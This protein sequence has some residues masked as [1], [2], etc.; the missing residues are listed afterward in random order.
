MA[1]FANDMRYAAC[2]TSPGKQ[3]RREFLAGAAA[4]GLAAASASGKA[5]AAQ[6]NAM[7]QRPIPSSGEMVPAVGMGTWITFN[8]GS[9]TA[10]RADRA[11]VLRTFFGMGGKMVDSSPMYGTSEEVIGDCLKRIGGT[12]PLLSATKVWTMFERFGITQ[13]ER[14]MELW[15]VP[16]F[17]LMQIHNLLDWDTHIKTLKEWKAAGRIRY[18]GITTS[19]GRRH[20]NFAKVMQSEPLDFVQ[21]SY[22]I[23]DRKAEE[24]LLPMAADLGQA[25]II[26]RPF[27]TGGLFEQFDRHPLPEWA[28]EFDASNWA[29]YFLKFVIS[30]PAVTCAIPATSRVDHMRENMGALTG[31]LPDAKLR[32]RMVQYV[33]S[34]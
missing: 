14:S 16:R 28:S 31:P 10:L 27:Q 12:P 6:S 25:V 29:Q 1:T 30:H 34:L 19:H 23:L 33:E 11:D 8:V 17:D 4:L 9:D 2:M 5:G 18:L 24:R 22:N 21:F 15:G 3:N 13:M 32:Q 7:Q 20:S 26:N